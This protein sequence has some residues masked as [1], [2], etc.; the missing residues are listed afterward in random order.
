MS[1]FDVLE[2]GPAQLAGTMP[3]II[4]GKVT[5][6]QD[7][8]KLGRVKIQLPELSQ[9]AETFWARVVRP[10]GGETHGIHF[11][12]EV[13]D[14]VLVSF[15][16]GFPEQAFVLGALWSKKVPPPVEE[17]K[18]PDQRTIISRSGHTICLDDTADGE[19]IDILDS[20]KQNM[21]SIDTANGTIT[22]SAE[23]QL[24]LKAGEGVT[25]DTTNGA[26]KLTAKTFEASGAD[27]VTFASDGAISI[28]TADAITIKGPSGVTV[29]DGALEVK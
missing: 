12:F 21:I 9:T 4:V 18:R 14:E 2:D 23:K 29:N 25:I 28:E 17:A 24:V 8:E 11:P 3:T 7:P 20:T 19:R 26:Y 22:I 10:A 5:N 16:G 27:S 13:G 6:I 1:D 15:A